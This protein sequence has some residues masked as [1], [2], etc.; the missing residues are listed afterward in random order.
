MY[1]FYATEHLSEKEKE[2]WL[3]NDAKYPPSQRDLDWENY[4]DAEEVKI[5]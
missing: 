3:R 2:E 1:R 5:F 4:C